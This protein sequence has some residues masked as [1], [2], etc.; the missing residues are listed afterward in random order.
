[1]LVLNAVALAVWDRLH[2]RLSLPIILFA[3]LWIATS[4]V[5]EASMYLYGAHEVQ[6]VPSRNL[7]EVPATMASCMTRQG[8]EQACNT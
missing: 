5:L 3:M 7:E 6:Q 2:H 8:E 1:M 4:R